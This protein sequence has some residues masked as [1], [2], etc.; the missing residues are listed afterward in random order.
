MPNIQTRL[1]SGFL[2]GVKKGWSSFVWM[3]KI[4]IPLSLAVTLL[5]WTGWLDKLDFLLEPLTRLI[6]LPPE[7]ALPIISGMVINLY[8][9][10]AIIT[11]MPFTLAQMTLIAVFNL[12]AHNLI[13]EGAI[14][15][16]SG[17]HWAKI[18]AI[19][20]GAAVVTVLIVSRFIGDTSQSVASTTQ[21]FQTPLLEL[22]RDW[23][24][25]MLRTLAKIFGI[26]MGIMIALGCLKSLGWIDH[27]LIVFR[28]LGRLFGLK[29]RTAMMF[30]SAVIFGV[31]YGGAVIIEET[32]KERFTREE[33]EYLHISIGI[34]H[35]MLEDPALFT[36]LGLHAFWMWV[37]KLIMAIAVVQSYRGFRFIKNRLA[38]Q[39]A[40][41]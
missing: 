33:L 36:A 24:L 25:G 18:T 30:M 37:P 11:V 29:E 1:K 6:N 31:L 7:A 21:A 15:H 2:E 12:I 41:A 35:A 40:A 27:I 34:N 10:I 22:S 39:P 16:K 28:P 9:C 14:Q 19:R 4:V 3:S 38:R 17:M 13:L 20:I 5:Q 32:K 26:I 8:A 23:A